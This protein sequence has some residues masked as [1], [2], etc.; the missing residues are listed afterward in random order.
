MDWLFLRGLARAAAHWDRQPAAL[1]AAL[2]GD[3]VHT[4]DLPGIATAVERRAPW[5][6]AAMV[7]DLRERWP[8][9]AVVAMSGAVREAVGPLAEAGID[10]PVL[11]K[12]FR[13]PELFSAV[14]LALDEMAD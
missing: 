4:L 6:V 5:S 9:I 1:E 2:P 12:P 14:R 3:R 7:G 10:A 11:A 8:R 13:L